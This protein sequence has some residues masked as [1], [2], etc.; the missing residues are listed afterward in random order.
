MHAVKP[1]VAEKKDHRAK[2]SK[3]I[4]MVSFGVQFLQTPSM[5]ACACV[6]VSGPADT[7]VL[8]PCEFKCRTLQADTWTQLPYFS[9]QSQSSKHTVGLEKKPSY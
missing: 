1:D 4:C 5:C 8:S 3:F 9:F 6:R 7:A 2:E